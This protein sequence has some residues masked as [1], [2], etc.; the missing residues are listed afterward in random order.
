MLANER[1][2]AE[3]WLVEAAVNQIRIVR[4]RKKCTTYKGTLQRQ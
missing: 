4:A 2:G 3:D 1:N